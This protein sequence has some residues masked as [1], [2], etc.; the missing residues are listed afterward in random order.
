MTGSLI[1]M[2]GSTLTCLVVGGLLSL[3]ACL[4]EDATPVDLGGL[5]PTTAS[6]SVPAAVDDTNSASSE[7]ARRYAEQQCFDDPT[8][9]EGVIEIVHPDT[10]QVVA[11]IEADCAEVRAEHPDGLDNPP[12]RAGSSE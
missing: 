5:A 12:P 4:G 8:A 6:T 10:K 1:R 7:L 9:T 3:P 2:R 11:R